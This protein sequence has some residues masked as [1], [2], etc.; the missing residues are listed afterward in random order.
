MEFPNNKNGM[1]EVPEERLRRVL[2]LYKPEFRYLFKAKTKYPMAEGSF[3]FGGSGY[4][5]KASENIT[6]PEAQLCL[7]QLA[8]VAFGEW[9]QEGKLFKT[10]MNF[11]DYL[12]ILGEKIFPS[13]NHLI[14]SEPMSKNKVVIPGK[15]LYV[16][17]TLYKDNKLG[18]LFIVS[19]KCEMENEILKGLVDFAFI[20]KP[21]IEIGK[22]TEIIDKEI[23]E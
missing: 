1:S 17:D 4:T 8:S 13:S 3:Q 22:K 12:K 14:F 6:L 9:L 19:L 10:E 20:A 21:F 11:D 5:E 18:D 2:T 15:I 23:S 7:E 16:N